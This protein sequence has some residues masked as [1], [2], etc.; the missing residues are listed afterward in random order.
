[1]FWTSFQSSIPHICMPVSSTIAR[2]CHFPRGFRGATGCG[3]DTGGHVGGVARHPAGPCPRDRGHAPARGQRGLRAA[4][5]QGVV[6]CSVGWAGTGQKQRN[7]FLAPEAAPAT[8]FEVLDLKLVVLHILLIVN[9]CMFLQFLL[10][11][12]GLRHPCGGPASNL[13]AGSQ[14]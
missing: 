6:D 3:P 1:M 14:P 13:L 10:F 9:C 11:E 2:R 5:L 8:P 7:Q 12:S 4:T